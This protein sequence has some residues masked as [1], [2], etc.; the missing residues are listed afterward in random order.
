MR[1]LP[2][3]VAF[4]A[5]V[6][7]TSSL[8]IPV[9]AQASGLVA[10]YGFEEGSGTQAADASGNGRAGAITGATW[11]ATGRFGSAL[12]FDGVDDW[13]T[14]ADAAALDLI[15]GMTLEAWVYP[16]ALGGWRS[17]VLKEG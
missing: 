9:A 2:C 8:E 1:R 12:V 4:A 11:T 14:V 10:A 17:A 3:V 7:L 15:T 16:T 5:V 13:V 6:G